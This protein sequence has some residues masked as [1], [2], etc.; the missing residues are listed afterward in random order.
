MT[1]EQYKRANSAVFP[2]VVIILGYI[3]VSMLLFA[4]SSTATW[5]TWLQL[6]SAVAGLVVSTATYVTARKT[7]KC[8]VIM[9]ASTAVVYSVVC[10]FGTTNGT[11]A[12]SIPV[13]FASMAYLNIRLVICGNAVS[14]IV[15]VVRLIMS[16]V[17]NDGNLEDM[18]IALIILEL[19]AFSSIRAEM[20]LNQFN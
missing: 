16:I 7:K 1:E 5:R 14:I 2:G 8:G 15:T 6:G 9:M 4:V 11:W 12:Y 3:A 17:N 18:V 19:L 20:L 13:L 10:L